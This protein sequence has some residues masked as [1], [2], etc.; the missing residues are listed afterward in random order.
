[1]LLRRHGH[2][3]CQLLLGLQRDLHHLATV[4]ALTAWVTRRRL[5]GLAARRAADVDRLLLLLLLLLLLWSRRGLGR[6]FDPQ[7]LRQVPLLTLRGATWWPTVL[8]LL[9]EAADVGTDLG[10]GTPLHSRRQHA[11]EESGAGEWNG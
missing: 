11:K 2:E 6:V 5:N 3:P 7:S 8:E 10:E 4:R 9:R 1:L